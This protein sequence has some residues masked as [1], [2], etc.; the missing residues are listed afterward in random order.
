ME[1]A[2]MV[3]AIYFHLQRARPFLPRE[4]RGTSIYDRISEGRIRAEWVP[5]AGTWGPKKTLAIEARE[6]LLSWG[7][8]VLRLQEPTHVER[9]SQSHHEIDNVGIVAA[10]ENATM[11]IFT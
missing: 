11:S 9:I 7:I 1:K 8:R 3:P 4:Q 5:R 6:D 10:D 2:T